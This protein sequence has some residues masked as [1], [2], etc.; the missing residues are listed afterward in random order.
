MSTTPNEPRSARLSPPD[1]FHGRLKALMEDFRDGGWKPT[2]LERRLA[3]LLAQSAAGTGSLSAGG[4][5]AV[6]WE[7]SIAAVY[8][9]GG[10]F[11]TL[12]G[13]LLPLVE[14]SDAAALHTAGLALDLVETITQTEPRRQTAF[15]PSACPCSSQADS[16]HSHVPPLRSPHAAE[17]SRRLRTDAAQNHNLLLNAAQRL[18]RERGVK[19]LTMEEVATAAGVGKGTLFRRFGD[20]TGLLQAMLQ[21]SE[22]TFQAAHLDNVDPVESRDQAV[23]QLRAFGIA[24]IR[25]YAKE[26]ELQMA[27][28][29]SPDQRYRRTPRRTYHERVGVLIRLATPDADA[30][31]LSHALLSYLEPALIW[32]LNDQCGLSLQRLENGWL[33]LVTRLTNKRL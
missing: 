24:A 10:R 27:A 14:R 31:L 4:I 25:R 16:A 26:L 2:G 15:P 8:E 32:H 9:N 5:R 19:H 3:E 29:P 33:E 12:L 18:A 17:S 23:A 1:N 7:G 20:R 28:E 30:E 6:L 22:D 11:V 13:D 21:R